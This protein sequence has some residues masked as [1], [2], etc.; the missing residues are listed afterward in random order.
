M[1][2]YP[3]PYGQV[4]TNLFLNAVAHAFPEGKPGTVDIQVRNTG[5][6]NVEGPVF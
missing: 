5:K 6:D 3:G 2:S 4:L 1:N